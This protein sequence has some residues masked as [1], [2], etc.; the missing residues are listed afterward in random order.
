MA[1]IQIDLIHIIFVYPRSNLFF[2]LYNSSPTADV[3][4]FLNYF[5]GIWKSCKVFFFHCIY[6][7][8]LTI[9]KTDSTRTKTDSKLV[10]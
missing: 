3:I 5:Y 8:K 10:Y 2:I 6:T 9:Q 7:F 1:C 4:K